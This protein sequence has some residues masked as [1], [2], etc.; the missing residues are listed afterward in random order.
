M[1]RQ[2]WEV[3]GFDKLQKKLKSLPDKM[4]RREVIKI[5]RRAARDTVKEARNQA[6]KS[7]RR[8]MF[9]P[10]ADRVAKMINP[11]NLRKSIGV[12]VAR[13]A[14]NPMI[15]VRPKSSGKYDGFYGRQ[16]V[17]PGHPKKGGGKVA[18]NPFM[19]RAFERTEG[20][21]SRDSVAGV[22]KYLK[23]LIDKL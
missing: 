13:Q 1:S 6:P 18:P 11:G 15:F 19:D 14:K 23:K 16:W 7:K 12:E 9:K 22:E 20:K 8:H 17:I 10:K 3:K 5:L 2:L 21:I 4:K